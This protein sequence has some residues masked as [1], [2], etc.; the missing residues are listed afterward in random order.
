MLLDTD[1]SQLQELQQLVREL[2]SRIYRIERAMGLEPAPADVQPQSSVQPPPPAPDQGQPQRL[3]EVKPIP[4]IPPPSK[5]LVEAIP[6]TG[7]E[8][9]I[10]SHWLN[11][12]G[13]AAV[14]IGVSYFLKFAFDNDWIGPAGRV[15]IGLLAGIAVVI[16]SE[17]FRRRGYRAFSY[18]LKAVGIGV[19]Y[20]SLWAAFH[21]YGLIPSG[22]AFVAMLAVTSA[23]A[24]MALSQDAEILA[25]FALAGGFSTP[26]LL[27]TGQNREVQLFSYLVIL[28][29]ATLVL[30]AIKPWRRL[31]MLSYVATVLLYIGWYSSFY[32]RGQL[33]L[34][35]GFATLFFAIFA[36]AP[37][38]AGQPENEIAAF[39]AVPL[40]L[41]LVNAGVY[42]LQIYAMYEEI[43]KNVTAWFALALAA[44]YIFLSRQMRRQSPGGGVAGLQLLHLALAIGFITIA[45]PIR[46][47]AHWITIG[48]FVEAGM[49]LWVANR[50]R[51]EF[52]NGFAAGVL[53]LGIARLLLFDNFYST[54][55]I[56]NSRMA[57]HAVAIAVLAV[58]A[59]YG[60]KRNDERGQIAAASAIVA[61]NVLALVALSREVSDY[62]AQKMSAVRPRLGQWNRSDRPSFREMEIERDFTY[63]ALWMGYGAI[64]M[65]MGFWRRSAF[66][67]WQGLLLIAATIVK[68]FVYDVSQL[69]RGYRILSFIVLGVLLLAISFVYQRDWLQLGG[70]KRAGREAGDA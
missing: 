45:I 39:S 53:V 51:S 55:L 12:I 19:L 23:T 47:D 11:R 58:V 18:S 59:R 49:L 64:L 6:E 57:T 27:S 2:T 43:D 20:L 44:V 63:S 61:L 46:L 35:L 14:L 54:R 10:G 62:Y 32:D 5:G 13:I 16:W 38:I 70:A 50:I 65:V 40:F 36:I 69:D 25:F 4:H 28:N 37:L 26:V 22:V 41:A 30:V 15:S 7:L 9:R 1:R 3:S 17:R 48:W 60:S 24:I 21:V 34:T 33:R 52:L 29:F 8:S 68:V 66:V 42:F 31:L 67:R 56:F